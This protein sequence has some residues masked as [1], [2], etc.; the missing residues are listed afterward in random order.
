MKKFLLS[1][2]A[3][4][5]FTAFSFA[6]DATTDKKK[7]E[8]K[9]PGK[10]GLEFNSRLAAEFMD[11][12]PKTND[13][14]DGD[15]YFRNQLK[16]SL[17]F[18]LLKIKD[19][20]GKEDVWFNMTPWIADRFDIKFESLTSAQST[21]KPRNRFYF[22]LDNTIKIPKIMDI[23]INFEY[24]IAS[25]LR[26]K[27]PSKPAPYEAVELR[28]SP[29]LSLSGKYDFGLSFRLITLF[30]LYFY[31]DYSGYNNNKIFKFF[32]IE[33]E[34][35]KLAFDFLHFAG[36]KDIKGGIFVEEWH[37]IDLYSD[38]FQK[39]SAGNAI[40]TA[41]NIEIQSEFAAGIEFDLYKVTPILGFYLKQQYIK[42]KEDKKWT[43]AVDGFDA[44]TT[45]YLNVYPGIKAGIGY[46]K[47]WFSF[48]VTYLGC[49][50][51]I[52]NGQNFS[53]LDD[54]YKKANPEGWES[55]FETAVTFKL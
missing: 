33:A 30:S 24:R 31:P 51:V 19:Q 55:R 45:D 40:K 13:I 50:Q 28:F 21:I 8:V 7:E 1:L 53:S 2:I 32:E 11:G 49:A 35:Y 12:Q 9:F 36:N 25:D 29:K 22:G 44:T 54:N 39:D 47:D 26:K 46:S 15:L 18:D 10:F 43:K 20:K 6:G 23:G 34:S 17:G 42:F 5:A 16:L 38:E 4:I 37:I 41:T 3:V 52:K 14:K 27:D 48:S